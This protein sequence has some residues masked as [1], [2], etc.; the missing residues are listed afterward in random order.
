MPITIKSAQVNYKDQ[1]NNYVS[2]DVVAEKTTAEMV[3]AIEEA[4]E[5]YLDT[6]SEYDVEHIVVASDTQ[7]TAESNRLWIDESTDE[8]VTIP[9]NEEFQE[10]KS[11]IN[12][13]P[14]LTDS[15]EEGPDL[16]ISDP[17]GNVIV[18]FEDGSIKVKDFDS[19][20]IGDLDELDT[21]EK[22]TL[23]GAINELYEADQEVE[24]KVAEAPKIVDSDATNVDLDVSDSRGNV[25]VRFDHGHIKTKG[26]DSSKTI[27]PPGFMNVD[28]DL[29][30]SDINGNILVKF[31]NGNIQ[32]KK[33]DSKCIRQLTGKKWTCLGDSLT[34]HNLRTTMNYHDYIA[35]ETGITVF[36]L[37]HS[38]CGYAKIGGNGQNFVNQAANIP[39]DTD[40]ITIFGSGND[41]SS[42]LEIGNPT[43]SGNTTLC[44]YINATIDTIYANHPT[45][46]LGI[47]TPTP[48]ANVEPSDGNTWMKRYSEAIVSICLLRGIP[49]LDL[50]HCSN[51][52]PSDVNFRPLAYSKDDGEGVHPDETGHALIAPR[53]RQ[54]LFTLI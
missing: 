14:K 45:T 38:G 37:G 44:G 32:T 51:L 39:N 11:A 7:P 33:F 29:A 54:F 8:E 16:D 10:V 50:W 1:Y 26:F 24:E 15:E 5:Q 23:V 46:P 17:N 21:T 19:A 30:V 25:L 36:N 9:T 31:S 28:A 22:E 49:Y 48:W 53:F 20:S 13:N 27:G 4:G 52:H 6:L 12:Q 42:G 3:E 40:V 35:Q 2:V 18:R 41:G 34:E 43:D 47:I